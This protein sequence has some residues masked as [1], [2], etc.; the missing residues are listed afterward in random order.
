MQPEEQLLGET[1]SRT[2]YG[3]TSMSIVFH[4]TIRDQEPL[5]TAQFWQV[6]AHELG[7]QTHPLYSCCK[8]SNNEEHTEARL[9]NVQF[10][11]VPLFHRFSVR[12]IVRF[13]SAEQF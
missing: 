2:T 13:R 10:S 3:A 1:R 5:E 12:T 4:E 7:H 6:C 9:M 11:S 8:L